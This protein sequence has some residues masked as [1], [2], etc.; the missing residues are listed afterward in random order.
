K[1]LGSLARRL[2]C[3]PLCRVFI[4]QGLFFAMVMGF[5]ITFTTTNEL[6]TL[7]FDAGSQA[8]MVGRVFGLSMLGSTNYV[9]SRQKISQW[10]RL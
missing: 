2:R 4:G 5:I 3:V 1:T 10:E 6:S 7:F 8:R 9:R